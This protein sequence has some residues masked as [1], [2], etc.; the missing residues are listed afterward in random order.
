MSMETMSFRIAYPN[1]NIYYG[2]STSNVL[3]NSYSFRRMRDKNFIL[4]DKKGNKIK[5]EEC[6]E[7]NGLTTIMSRTKGLNLKFTNVFINNGNKTDAFNK[8]LELLDK[9]NK[10]K[11]D[12]PVITFGW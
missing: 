9:E 1:G 3:L 2:L 12:E 4:L 8:L 6:S 7:T 5:V 10:M 11:H